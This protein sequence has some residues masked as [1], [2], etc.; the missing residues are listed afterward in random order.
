MALNKRN[1]SDSPGKIKIAEA[2]KI[3]LSEKDFDSITTAD[4][5][6]TSGVNEAPIYRYCKDKRGLLHEVLARYLEDH[7]AKM[8]LDRKGIKGAANKLRNTR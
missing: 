5:S 7:V 8:E 4:I 1:H 2:L 3:L 6:R